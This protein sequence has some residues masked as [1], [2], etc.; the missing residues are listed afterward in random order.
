[1]VART[2]RLLRAVRMT[3]CPFLCRCASCRERQPVPWLH[4]V[5]TADEWARVERMRRIAEVAQGVRRASDAS[6]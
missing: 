2:G 1:M 5:P 3:G 4:R 6:K